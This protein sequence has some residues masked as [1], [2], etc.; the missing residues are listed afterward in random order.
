MLTLIHLL[1][2]FLKKTHIQQFFL[3][4]LFKPKLH[5]TRI[6]LEFLIFKRFFI[7]FLDRK[8]KMF[9][10]TRSIP[11][12]IIVIQLNFAIVLILIGLLDLFLVLFLQQ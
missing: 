1:Y 12:K 7:Y 2:I 6:Q 11:F 10:F 8:L 9:V 4:T 3:L 5:L